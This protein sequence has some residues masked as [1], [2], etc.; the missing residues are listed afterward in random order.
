VTS[1]HKNPFV[2]DLCQLGYGIIEE[3]DDYVLLDWGVA[4]RKAD[5]KNAPDPIYIPLGSHVTKEDM[6][7]YFA[8]AGINMEAYHALQESK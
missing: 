5:W 2:D 7:E 8:Q 6:V 1:R 3:T 4:W